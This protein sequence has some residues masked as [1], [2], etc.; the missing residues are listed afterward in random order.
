M[1]IP[2]LPWEIVDNC[3]LPSLRIQYEDLK[4]S[5]GYSR[6]GLRVPRNVVKKFVVDHRSTTVLGGSV[7]VLSRSH[8]GV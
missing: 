4:I 2:G 8:Y 3:N 5:Y 6:V 7:T 1:A